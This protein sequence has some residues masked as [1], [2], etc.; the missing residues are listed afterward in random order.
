MAGLRN[1]YP[2]A[3]LGV[4]EQGAFADV[5]LID[6]NPLE[7]ITLVARAETSMVV[8]MKNGTIYKNTLG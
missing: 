5:L 4:I 8:I 1:P 3:P 7:D 2:Q 6:G